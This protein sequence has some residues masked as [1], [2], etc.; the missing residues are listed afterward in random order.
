MKLNIWL[1]LDGKRGHEKQIE[2]LAFMINQKIKTNIIKIKKISFPNTIMNLLRIGNDPC[3]YLPRPNLI[4]AAGHHTHLDA[5]QKKSKYGGKVITIMKPS[6]PSF[7]FDLT[8]IPSHDNII[9]NKNV[10]VTDGPVSKIKNNRKQK[11]N[12]GI[13]LIGGPSKNFYWSNNEVISNVNKILKSNLNINFTVANSRRTP[14]DFVGEFIKS[15]KNL[16]FINYEDVS[17]YW[18]EKNI[19]TFEFSWVTQ[20]SIS[21]LYELLFSGSKVT[22]ISLKKKNNKFNQLFKKLYD[23]K[24]INISN[25]KYQ[26]INPNIF[27]KSIAEKCASFICENLIDRK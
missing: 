17:S 20:D 27:E 9:W 16:K 12:T 21:M 10:L 3:E 19:G 2:D 18:L 13:I 1:I 15:H 5:L 6:I 8:I 23:S 7:F 24:K 25:F 26:K 14:K 11:K 4:I 22:I